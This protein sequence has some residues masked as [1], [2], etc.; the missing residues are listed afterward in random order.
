MEI[1]KTNELLEKLIILQLSAQG[2]GV[3]QIAKFIGKRAQTI[4]DL[5]KPLKANSEK[6]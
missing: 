1:K 5:L 4:N 2:V 3:N 6:A